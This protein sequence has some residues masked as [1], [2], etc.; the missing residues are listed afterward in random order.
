MPVRV[1]TLRGANS[2]FGATRGLPPLPLPCT[3]IPGNAI[4]AKQ[5][6]ISEG[7]EMPRPPADI[8][9][10][11]QKHGGPTHRVQLSRQFRMRKTAA[12]PRLSRSSPP[13]ASCGDGF[14]CPQAAAL[15]CS[16]AWG[17]VHSRSESRPARGN[18]PPQTYTIQCSVHLR[19]KG[20][21]ARLLACSYSYS[22]PYWCSSMLREGRAPVRAPIR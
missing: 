10:S 12:A 9:I 16:W 1:T 15:N 19:M 7:Q 11:L 17:S 14:R 18:P 8:R 20:P 4:S 13:T 21:G 2:S 5:F 22:C 6:R 3:A